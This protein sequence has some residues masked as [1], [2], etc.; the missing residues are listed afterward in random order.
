MNKFKKSKFVILFFVSISLIVILI[1]SP[2]STYFISLSSNVV[3][4][5]DR[6]ISRPF[7]FFLSER[8]SLSDWVETYKENEKLKNSLYALEEKANKL[9]SLQDE[10]T[11]LRQ[12]LELKEK[13]TNTVKITSE[14]IARTPSA[15]KSELTIDKG[16]ASDITNS[17]IAVSN[18]GVIGAVTK[19]STDSSVVT[20]LSNEKN[21]SQI[22]VKIQTESGFVYGIVS[23]FDSEKSAFVVTQLNSFDGI[24]EGASVLTSGLGT[25]NAENLL[26]GKVLSV[27]KGKDQLNDM[28][29]VQPAADLSDI[30]A[31]ILVRN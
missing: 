30:Q 16:T 27:S 28:L 4:T 25:Y 17:M 19:V 31:V 21:S 1:F 10:N 20:L 9:D 15:W 23:G 12:L 8:D 13:D 26:V 14:V 5:I 3:S 6:V 29:L 2:F 7:T 24:T 22:S 11:Q 18:G